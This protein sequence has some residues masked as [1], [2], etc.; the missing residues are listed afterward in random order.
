M[1]LITCNFECEASSQHC[2][3]TC[4]HLEALWLLSRLVINILSHNYMLASFPGP[5]QLSVASSTVKQGEP[6]I[7][8]HVSK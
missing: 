7:F 6:G 3:V 8:S 5:T 1:S 4:Q 2:L